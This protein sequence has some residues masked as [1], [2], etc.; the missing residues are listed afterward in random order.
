MPMRAPLTVMVLCVACGAHP[1]SLPPRAESEPA[2][3]TDEQ[4]DSKR[5]PPEIRTFFFAEDAKT[6]QASLAAI[7][8]LSLVERHRVDDRYW[9][10]PSTEWK[11]LDL[12]EPLFHHTDIAMI[13]IAPRSAYPREL[14]IDGRPRGTRLGGALLFLRARLFDN[15]E[16]IKQGAREIDTWQ[17]ALDRYIGAV[18]GHD[19]AYGIPTERPDLNELYDPPKVP[20]PQELRW[21]GDDLIVTWTDGRSFRHEFGGLCTPVETPVDPWVFFEVLEGSYLWNKRGQHRLVELPD[22]PV[23]WAPSYERDLIWVMTKEGIGGLYDTKTAYLV[24]DVPKQ[25]EQLQGKHPSAF[26]HRD[27]SRTHVTSDQA[28]EARYPDDAEFDAA[29][30][31][32]D[33]EVYSAYDRI[34]DRAKALGLLGIDQPGALGRRGNQFVG[35][36][37][38]RTANNT[39]IGF[40]F[41]AS[42]HDKDATRLALVDDLGIMVLSESDEVLAILELSANC[43][44]AKR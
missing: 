36:Y 27:G 30:R 37:E 9:V 14:G 24:N 21:H 33:L 41:F 40:P 44:K 19:V 35:F 29:E 18:R 28:L 34:S 15:R 22:Y 5:M 38:G 1:S 25:F 43:G 7:E 2:M 13:P 11:R 4:P 16:V 39:Q 32:R 17:Q 6:V 10:T 20:R 31:A 23:V 8:K 3:R 26:L 12:E 42:A